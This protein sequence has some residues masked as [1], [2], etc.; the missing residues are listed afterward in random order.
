[1]PGDRPCPRDPED[2]ALA[3]FGVDNRPDYPYQVKLR[4]FSIDF[5]HD[6][7]NVRTTVR[8][9]VG[10]VTTH[11]QQTAHMARDGISL[12]FTKIHAIRSLDD[13][14]AVARIFEH[15]EVVPT[16]QG[17]EAF[18][19]RIGD[20]GLAV[21]KGMIPSCPIHLMLRELIPMDRFFYL[22]ADERDAMR[23]LSERMSPFFEA[24]LE[25]VLECDA[26]AV[27]WGTNFDQD[28]T[29]PPFFEGEIVPWLQKVSARLHGS[30]K[31]LLVHTDGENKAL[32]PYYPGCG[33]DIAES[34]C[35]HPMTRCTL[36][37]IREG[38]GPETTV[39]GGIPSIALLA[40]M[41]DD[42]AFESYLD[43]LFESIG[44][45]ERLIL[46]VSDNVPPDADLGRLENI[47]KR[48]DAHG[49]V[50]RSEAAG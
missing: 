16:P 41:M 49:R 8:T 20:R 32:L 2:M 33:F 19:N 44:T 3:G 38:V 5:H 30:G 46:G 43:R 26:E 17:Y 13:F 9:P 23:R 25:A 27:L 10:D 15:L 47:G 4:D 29:W 48:I 21:A 31:Y 36:S 7:E 40:D 50:P 39:W 18:R 24:C 34:V 42:S 28:L 22:Y 1:M 6:S 45:G 37:E 14:E 35:P 11:R 12:P